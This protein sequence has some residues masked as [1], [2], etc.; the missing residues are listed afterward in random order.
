MPSSPSPF[1]GP[2]VESRTV[3]ARNARSVA[4]WCS[5]S[6]YERRTAQ[7]PFTA[8]AVVLVPAVPHDR[9]AL[10]GDVVARYAD[11][12]FGVLPRSR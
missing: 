11:G 5:G 12:S 4:A 7:D 1:R 3:S 9:P 2:V 10:S 8:E 6:A